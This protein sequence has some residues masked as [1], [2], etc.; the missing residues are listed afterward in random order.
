MTTK[1]VLTPLNP[2]LVA[3]GLVAAVVAFYGAMA[4]WFPAAYIWATYEDLYGEWAQT[5]LFLIACIFSFLIAWR[6]HHFRWFFGLL[7][8]ACLYVV[9][10]EISWGQRIFGFESPELFEKHNIQGE[11]NL[12]NLVTGPIDTV[13]KDTIEYTL[14]SS[15]AI[16]GLIYPLLVAFGARPAFLLWRLGVPAPPLFLSPAFVLAA[17]LEIGLFSFNE[18][19]VAEILVSLGLAL[20]AIYYWYLGRSGVDLARPPTLPASARS[21][22]ATG[23]LVCAVTVVIL[24]VGTTWTVY[25]NPARRADIDNRL[26]NGY[27]KFADRYENYDR[28][29]VSLKLNL[30]VFKQEPGR[31]ALMRTIAD[32]YRDLGDEEGFKRFNNLA[33]TTLQRKYARDPEKVSTNLALAKTYRQAGDNVAAR[34]YAQRAN[35]FALRRV[36]DKP[37]SANR[38]YWLARTYRELGDNAL[39]LQHYRRAH[40]LKPT[41]RKYRKAYLRLRR[42]MQA[43]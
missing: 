12:H 15:L 32:N 16:Y 31:T 33:L 21:A 39:A 28:Y 23:F 5:Y 43:D 42:S 17:P 41:S 2:A 11:T 20:M 30:H 22:L 25:A 10:E 19:E 24:A 40:E 3:L 26:L 6:G 27:E 1:R 35:R 14:A 36:Q 37:D 38:A 4:L 18:A 34:R 29:D 8:L 9:L 7:A 13:I